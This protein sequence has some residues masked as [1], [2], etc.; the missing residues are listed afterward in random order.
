MRSIRLAVLIGSTLVAALLLSPSSFAGTLAPSAAL[1]EPP[2][3]FTGPTSL[4][5]G[6][7]PNSVAVRDFNGDTYPD[8]AVANQFSG[9]V[10]VLLGTADGTFSDPNNPINIHT[11]GFPSSVAVGDFNGDA[12]PDLAIADAYSGTIS[13]L[14]GNAGGGFSLQT[15]PPYAAGSFPASIAVGDFNADQHPDLAVADQLTGDILMLRGRNDGTFIRPAERVATVAEPGS[16]VVANLNSDTDPDLVV[17]EHVSFGSNL[18]RV[19]VLLGSTDATFTT[20]AEVAAG[21]DPVPV[22]VGDFD[23]D[24]DADLAVADQSPGEILVLL[25]AGNGS[26][27][28]LSTLTADSGLSGIAVGDFN[29]D[30]DPDLAAANVNSGEVSVFVGGAGGSF[31]GPTNFSA[32]SF[33]NSVAVG[34]FN[35]DARPDLVFTNAGANSLSV[36]LNNTPATNQAPVATADTYGTAEDTP[37]PVNAPGVLAND[38]DPDNDPLSAGLVSGPSHGTLTLNPDGSFVY[39]PATNHTGSDS[40]TYQ[41]SDGTLTSN[42]ATVTI[43]VSAANDAPT[44]TV[45]AGGTCGRDD[46]SGT[47]NLAVADEESLAGVLTLSVLSS[48]PVLVPTGNVGFVGNGTARTMTVNAVDGRS[49]TAIL[50]VT[51]SDGQATGTTVTITVKVGGSG[52]DTLTG[53]A[54]ADLLL[55][56]SNNDSLTGGDGYD[57]LCGDSG[58]DTLS[59]GRGDDSLGGGSGTDQLTGGSGADRFSGGSGTDTATDYSAAEGDFSDGTIP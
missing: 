43:T 32:G 2:V 11:G 40:F 44:V 42:L 7:F 55:A 25:G 21:L 58:G 4:D 15:D 35:A 14:F 18:S 28:G 48:N 33:P 31:A 45:A 56:Q 23:G 41:A 13:V 54:G 51:V 38:S 24:T 1:V 27:T 17:A 5:A 30:G 50:T 6:S 49:G 39:T 26:F 34:D 59:G 46:H 20:P 52:K 57:L 22:A 12:R 8:L 29:R 36:L 47:V 37:L 53:T 9:N 19:L 10:S 16:V 3:S